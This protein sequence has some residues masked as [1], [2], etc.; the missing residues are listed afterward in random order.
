MTTEQVILVDTNDQAIG[1]MEKLLAHQ[2]GQLHRAFSIFVFDDSEGEAK[3]L[4]QQR[5]ANKYH[6]ANLWTNT[7]CSHPRAD[8]E[9]HTAAE[10]RL[11]EEFGIRLNTFIEAGSFI[12]KAK[13][14]NQLI[15]HELDHVLVATT[16]HCIP[17]P[18][19]E[20]I[21]QYKWMTVS[22][23]KH[24]YAHQPEQWTAWFKQ[25]FEIAIKKRLALKP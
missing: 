15:E 5:A 11:N 14:D 16:R 8:E 10:R 19:P 9:L 24:S 17:I 2:T 20:E 1:S 3:L 6:S 13:L 21:Q 22:D 23:I 7:C 12:Y 18:N 25:S 4:V